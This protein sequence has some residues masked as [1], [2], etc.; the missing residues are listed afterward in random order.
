S[1][2][3][4]LNNPKIRLLSNPGVNSVYPGDDTD[5]DSLSKALAVLQDPIT[6][7]K[8]KEVLKDHARALS[9][10]VEDAETA[11]AKVRDS[12]GNAAPYKSEA[13]N[14]VTQ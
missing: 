13:N 4:F 10:L 5:Y 12:I 2:D 9:Y 7:Q 3:V 14:F 6:V 1:L 8:V 11:F